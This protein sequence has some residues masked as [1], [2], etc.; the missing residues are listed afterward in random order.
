MIKHDR[1]RRDI[2]DEENFSNSIHS[3]LY[4]GLEVIRA[5]PPGTTYTHK[6][7]GTYLVPASFL[8][9]IFVHV[10]ISPT[11]NSLFATQATGSISPEFACSLVF[12]SQTQ[13]RE[14]IGISLHIYNS[15]KTPVRCDLQVIHRYWFPF[16]FGF[17]SSQFSFSLFVFEWLL[18][19][20]ASLAPQ[21][22]QGE[23]II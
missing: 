22:Q 8:F 18:I 11:P 9:Y 23:K 1:F 7:H 15:R 21:S 13:G 12:P 4:V 20:D 2:W 10:I 19:L 3:L 5:F 14:P 6:Q 16:F 17:R